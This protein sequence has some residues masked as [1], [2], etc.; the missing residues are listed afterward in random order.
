[1]F[2]LLLLPVEMLAGRAA[3][4]MENLMG[5]KMYK[6]DRMPPSSRL[7]LQPTAR[8]TALRV[9]S[10]PASFSSLSIFRC[11]VIL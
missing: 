2:S 8:Q 6:S 5:G 4:T 3:S 7:V 9:L 1:M 11:T 10:S